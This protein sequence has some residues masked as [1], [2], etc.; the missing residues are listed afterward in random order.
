MQGLG[1]ALHEEVTI[2]SNGCVRQTG[3]ETY[4]VLLALDV[5]PVEISLYEGAP[6]IGPLGT[7][8]AG[9]VPILNVG[10]A[11]A[12]A[13]ANATGKRVQELPLTPPR[14]L[15][16]LLDRNRPLSLPHIA[17][18]WANNLVRPHGTAG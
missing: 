6:S 7:K 1:Y 15:E 18:A 9:E 3:F 13:V 14:V 2:G 11:I 16:L 12:C 17:D 8:G 4:R 10:A 5:V